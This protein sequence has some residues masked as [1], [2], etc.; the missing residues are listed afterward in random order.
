[1][2]VRLSE[3]PGLVALRTALKR[4]RLQ[5]VFTCEG[6]APWW[7]TLCIGDETAEQL[8]TLIEAN[9][10]AWRDASESWRDSL[11]RLVMDLPTLFAAQEPGVSQ[12]RQHAAVLANSNRHGHAKNVSRFLRPNSCRPI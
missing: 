12:R 1:V 4:R 7:T 11:G 9:K 8:R 10:E 6:E 3:R 5:V 2:M